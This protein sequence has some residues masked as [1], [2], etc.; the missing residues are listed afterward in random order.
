MLQRARNIASQSAWIANPPFTERELAD[1]RGKVHIV[2]GGY[3]GVGL[4][5]VKLL[6]AAHATVYVAGRSADK[7][8]Q[9]IDAVKK[10]QPDGGRVEFLQLDL[11][12]LASIKKSADEFVAKE[13]RLDVL[14]NNAGVMFPPKGSVTEEGHELQMGTNCLGPFLF[15]Q[16]LLPLL[17]KTAVASPPGSVRVTWAASLAT[18]LLSP[19]HGVDLDEATG[20]PKVLGLPQQNYGQSKSGNVLLGAEFARRHRE[21]GIVST[22]TMLYP[23][24]KGA[25]TE[26]YAGWSP[27]ISL[28]NSGCY[29]VPWGRIQTPRSG[30]EEAIKRKDEGGAGVAEKFWGWC[31]KE[32]KAFM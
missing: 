22:R 13:E 1:Q 18:D 32:T 3:S 31:E 27:D 12:H 2:T 14:T 6:H 16:L 9:A 19:A 7:A 15:T 30:I 21:D 17:R 25:Y 26:L 11:A 4:E 20:A 28:E 5:L 10:A 23:A 24:I 29:V 8:A